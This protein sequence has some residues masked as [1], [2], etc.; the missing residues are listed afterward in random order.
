MLVGDDLPPA[1]DLIGEL[2]QLL[3]YRLGRSAQH[4]MLGEE[5]VVHLVRGDVAARILDD[6]VEQLELDVDLLEILPPGIGHA[7]LK[8]EPLG[9][10]IGVRD[11]HVAAH[12]IAPAVWNAAFRLH[13]FGPCVP[14]R[15]H[16]RRAAEEA[17]RR[18]VALAGELHGG[19]VHGQSGDRDL[20][21]VPAAVRTVVGD[22]DP[23][24][25]HRIGP[26]K[27]RLEELALLHERLALPHPL[28]QVQRLQLARGQTADALEAVQDGV[29]MVPTRRD[30]EEVASLH[31][32]AEP[33][34]ADRERARVMVR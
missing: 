3:D 21:L 20:Q 28:D 25:R 19:R 4:D 2:L 13:R 22:L 29:G 26:G 27:T 31:Y 18:I 30:A 8:I 10:R 12:A 11:E 15:R 33:A 23:I 9:L 14:M 6:P 16:L 1:A 34:D 17:D 24:F 7:A 5:I 32:L